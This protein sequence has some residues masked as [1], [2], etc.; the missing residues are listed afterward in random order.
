[1]N[2]GGTVSSMYGDRL[3]IG[4]RTLQLVSITGFPPHQTVASH[5]GSHYIGSRAGKGY[6][7]ITTLVWNVWV[8]ESLGAGKAHVDDLLRHVKWPRIVVSIVYT[9][10]WVA[11]WPMLKVQICTQQRPLLH[12]LYHTPLQLLPQPAPQALLSPLHRLLD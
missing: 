2:S 7:Q 12:L 3:C 6:T 4:Y 5:G 1:M 10:L 9:S 8:Q 11:F